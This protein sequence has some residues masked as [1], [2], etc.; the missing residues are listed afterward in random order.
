[1]V[2]QAKAPSPG[3]SLA[4]D[5]G[6]RGPLLGGIGILSGPWFA[7][8]SP[9]V[10]RKLFP[11]E[12]ERGIGYRLSR[13]VPRPAPCAEQPQEHPVKGGSGRTSFRGRKRLRCGRG[14]DVLEG[15]TGQH[16]SVPLGRRCCRR[17]CHAP[18]AV[19]SAGDTANDARSSLGATAARCLTAPGWLAGI[20]AGIVEHSWAKEVR[21]KDR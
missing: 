2:S 7:R 13:L 9:S 1:M 11:Y 8:S 5:S 4:S 16:V 15:D 20:I 10:H 18:Y 12:G 17:G 21:W 6:I 14:G 3:R 19:S